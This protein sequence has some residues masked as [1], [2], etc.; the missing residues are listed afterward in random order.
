MDAAP[1]TVSDASLTESQLALLALHT[2]TPECSLSELFQFGGAYNLIP[3]LIPR[4]LVTLLRARCLQPSGPIDGSLFVPA[5]SR[6][7]DTGTA[8]IAAS[9][10]KWGISRNRLDGSTTRW[11]L[12]SELTSDD[13]AGLSD[14]YSHWALQERPA[15][16]FFA[17]HYAYAAARGYAHVGRQTAFRVNVIF[18]L[19]TLRRTRDYLELFRCVWEAANWRLEYAST[20]LQ[21]ASLSLG[22]L[23]W[24]LTG[25]VLGPIRDLDHLRLT[26]A[27][28]VAGL[29]ARGS[30]YQIRNFPERLLLKPFSRAEDLIL[31]S[32]KRSNPDALKHVFGHAIDLIEQTVYAAEEMLQPT[33][34]VADFEE[35][36]GLKTNL[37]LGL[38]TIRMLAVF[39]SLT[40][41]H[42]SLEKEAGVELARLVRVIRDLCV[43]PVCSALSTSDE[44]DRAVHVA[45]AIVE[46]DHEEMLEEVTRCYDNLRDI[47]YR[48]TATLI[49][50]KAGNETRPT[51][52]MAY[53]ICLAEKIAANTERVPEFLAVLSDQTERTAARLG[54]I[55][56]WTRH[57]EDV[58]SA[59]RDELRCAIAEAIEDVQR[60][61]LL[62]EDERSD[63]LDA[64]KQSLD[65]KT[66]IEATVGITTIYGADIRLKLGLGVNIG[67]VISAIYSQIAELRNAGLTV[68]DLRSPRTKVDE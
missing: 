29:E 54:E 59:H 32:L 10:S 61:V 43:G 24:C 39:R 66:T 65:A 47:V 64:L 16:S 4:D 60:S 55:V 57:I 42:E 8:V 63:L 68:L 53:L 51:R 46:A 27:E 19:D 13:I 33:K 7:T 34:A 1:A 44:S 52:D 58:L 20:I 37:D 45:L 40:E 56:G 18:A 5:C 31:L 35:R 6:V 3:D 2:H 49:P 36:C 25:C 14:A 38:R 26:I 11:P 9:A 48:H 12:F 50:P 23:Y 62:S 67:K 15:G 28:L 21:H 41:T 30:G 22:R 17:G